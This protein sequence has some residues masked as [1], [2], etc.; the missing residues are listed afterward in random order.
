MI[1]KW[2]LAGVSLV[3]LAVVVFGPASVSSA[4]APAGA[5]L[6]HTD[7]SRNCL[8]FAPIACP[9]DLRAIPIDGPGLTGYIDPRS[10]TFLRIN[11]VFTG[12]VTQDEGCGSPLPYQLY[13][14]ATFRND[15]RRA[16]KFDLVGLTSQDQAKHTY[17][18]F[19]WGQ[20]PS[21]ARPL[22]AGRSTTVWLPYNLIVRPT[23][24]TLRWA[25]VNASISASPR[26]VARYQVGQTGVVVCRP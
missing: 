16:V 3:A 13:V 19:G 26:P 17:T 25:F 7:S 2:S 22:A 23:S 6:S 14:S 5:L 21:H 10:R 4:Q 18:P 15:S 9:S 12:R 8:P 1:L 20:A 11:R 24:L